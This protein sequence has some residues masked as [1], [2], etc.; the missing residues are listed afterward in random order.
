VTFADYPAF[1][2][3]LQWLIEGDELTD[4]FSTDVLDL[5]VG[6]GEARV[7]RDLRASTMLADL[8]ATVTA[9]A[10]TLPAGLLELKEVWFSGA[11]PLE[12][13]PLDRLRTLEAD[14]TSTGDARF[15]AQD[16]DTLRFWP[17]ASGTVLGRYYARPAD[18]KTVT[19]A[20]ATT[21]ARYPEVFIYASLVEA[22]PFLGMADKLAL[23][24]GKYQQAL[25]NAQQDER[26]RVL[27]GGPLRMRAR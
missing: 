20:Q 9:N 7:Y 2:V 13:I 1:R 18:L 3:A 6:L 19:W 8:S 23:W 22:V 16:G 24:E 15:C 11:R 10:A 26:V 21:F 17:E 5:I 25:A 27:S 14:G 4:T 12:I